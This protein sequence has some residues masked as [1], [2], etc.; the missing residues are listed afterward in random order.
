MCDNEMCKLLV[1]WE[2][3]YPIPDFYRKYWIYNLIRVVLF[4][5]LNVYL[6]KTC[7]I[8]LFKL[9]PIWSYDF[10]PS[11]WQFLDSIPK[12]LRRFGSQEWIKPIFVTL[13]WCEPYSSKGVLHRPEQ[14]VVRRGKVWTIKRVGLNLPSTVFQIVLN[15]NSN[16]GP[17]VVIMENYR[18]VSG[19]I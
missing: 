16:M 4:Q 12:K 11:F 15:R 6:R 10:F 2:F 17:S 9:L 18:L 5:N 14:M 3:A 19:R 1:L 8:V 7:T 13:F